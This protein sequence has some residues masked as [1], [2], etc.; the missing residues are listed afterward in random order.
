[1]NL[2]VY[3]DAKC[4]L[5][6]G[7]GSDIASQRLDELDRQACDFVEQQ[8]QRHPDRS[9]LA[10]DMG[11]GAGGL[12][13]ALAAAEA[14]CLGIDRVDFGLE[15]QRLSDS[16]TVD[17]K[18]AP[19]KLRFLLA[20]FL[21]LSDDFLSEYQS[22]AAAIVSQRALHYAPFS[23]AVSTIR[24]F[25]GLLQPDGRFFLGLSGLGSELGDGYA[26]AGQPLEQRFATLAKSMAVIH[27]IQQPICLYDAVDVERLLT[28]GGF[29]P[30]RIFTSAFGNLKAIARPTEWGKASKPI[31]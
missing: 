25:R 26:A 17:G 15:F 23:R 2:N 24:R 9:P 20:D 30:E 10:L 8:R 19:G 27:G 1:M 18:P 14:D 3:G 31:S 16:R 29:T 4:D 5:A 13:A 12:S 11:C 6:Q 7:H 22:A 21:D 28:E